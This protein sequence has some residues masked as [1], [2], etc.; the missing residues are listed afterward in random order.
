MDLF[1]HAARQ[2]ND[3][4]NDTVPLANPYPGILAVTQSAGDG[5]QSICR[6]AGKRLA[7]LNV[8]L[9]FTSKDYGAVNA[10]L[11]TS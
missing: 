7:K 2:D 1:V 9:M 10:C 5:E 6:L 4:H 3:I 11:A 8:I